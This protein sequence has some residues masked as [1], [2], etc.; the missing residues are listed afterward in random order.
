MQA[1]FDQPV[2]FQ[3]FFLPHP[4]IWF[5]DLIPL[6]FNVSTFFR[7]VVSHTRVMCVSYT[8]VFLCNFTGIVHG[9][10]EVQR[11]EM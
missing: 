8:A 4:L 11:V 10:V 2:L 5:K 9:N 3:M 7:L 6:L 1:Y